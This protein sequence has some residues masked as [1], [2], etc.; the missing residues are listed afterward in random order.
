M[1]TELALH[2]HWQYSNRIGALISLLNVNADNIAV[3][4]FVT[5]QH[6]IS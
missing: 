5:D 1:R 6:F 4:E 3:N 2:R